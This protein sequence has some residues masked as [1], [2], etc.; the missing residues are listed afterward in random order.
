MDLAPLSPIAE[1]VSTHTSL[2]LQM[3][4]TINDSIN[5][6]WW[7][8]LLRLAALC[9]ALSLNR[10]HMWSDGP[11]TVKILEL[12]GHNLLA[13]TAHSSFN[14]RYV[15]E[16]TEYVLCAWVSTLIHLVS[17]LSDDPKLQMC[18]SAAFTQGLQSC[19]YICLCF[20]TWTK[21]KTENIVLFICFML[22]SY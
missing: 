15:S 11:H 10:R 4:A 20:S 5:G 21:K 14:C 3:C 18:T 22:C 16:C 8:G 19:V 7:C 17:A 6:L 12:H 1:W 2:S 9:A 13:H